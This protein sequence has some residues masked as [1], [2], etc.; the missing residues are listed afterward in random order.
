MVDDPKVFIIIL[1]WNGLK[2]TLECLD[3]V[4]KLDYRNFEVIIVDNAS[5]DNSIN[6]IREAYPQVTLIKNNENLGFTGGNNV[7][8]RYA[9][10]HDAD[11]M[12]LLNNDT[13]VERD[14]VSKIIEVAESS[15]IIGLV[16]PMVYYYDD[17][18]K[19]QFAGS[20]MDWDSFSLIYPDSINEVGKEFQY[21]HNVCLW[22]TALLIKRSMVE[23]VGYLKEEY[24]AYWEDTEYS[25]RGIANGFHNIVCTSAKIFHKSPIDPSKRA[26]S[27]GTYY[28]YFFQRN[29]ILLAHE[30]IKTLTKRLKFKIRI[31]AELSNDMGNPHSINIDD[32]VTGT[33]HGLKSISGPMKNSERMPMSLRLILLLFSK[34]HPAFLFDLISLDFKKV[35]RKI[36]EKINHI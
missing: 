23:K 36:I 26:E 34:F 4:Y 9:M 14:T 1:N 29:Q 32:C 21:G 7:A 27:K 5:S 11:Y 22:G 6:I 16:S 24:F 3:S 13:I 28:C 35:H 31:L 12:W 30:Y 20:Y 15:G 33:W 25:L 8:M 19:W 17:P 2:D 18:N 10:A